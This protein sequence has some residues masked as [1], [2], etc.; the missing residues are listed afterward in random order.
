VSRALF[1]LSTRADL[2]ILADINKREKDTSASP[3][4]FQSG[5]QCPIQTGGGHVPPAPQP[6]AAT[7]AR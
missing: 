3:P 6:A 7:A 1:V 4:V 2:Q 5:E